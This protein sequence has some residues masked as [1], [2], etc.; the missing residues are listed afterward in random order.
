IYYGPGTRNYTNMV[1]VGSANSVSVSNLVSGTTYYF[2]ATSYT[3][4]GL[5]SDYSAEALYT[6]PTNAVLSAKVGSGTT[7]NLTVSG[8]LGANYQIQYATNLGPATVWL[9]LRTYTQTNFVQTFNLAPTTRQ[10]FFRV[11]Q[12]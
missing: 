1:P 3:L 11:Q 5:E 10:A 8:F 2:A 9:P 12:Q 4:A 7:W 6:A